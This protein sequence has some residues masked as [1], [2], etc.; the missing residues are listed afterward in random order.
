VHDSSSSSE[1][2]SNDSSDS[3]SSHT[4]YRLKKKSLKNKHSGKKVKVKKKSYSDRRLIVFEIF[5]LLL[6]ALVQSFINSV[7]KETVISVYNA[8]NAEFINYKEPILN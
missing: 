3:D 8:L 5:Q 4:C 6:K 2:S 7:P 1:F